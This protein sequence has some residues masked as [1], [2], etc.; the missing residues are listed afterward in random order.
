MI[1]KVTRTVNA[2][3]SSAT[4]Y[5]QSFV[6]RLLTVC[7]S[8]QQTPATSPLLLARQDYLASCVTG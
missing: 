7:S 6:Q 4:K 2:T 5:K 3:N 8:V 1:K